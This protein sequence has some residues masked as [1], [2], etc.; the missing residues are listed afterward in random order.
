MSTLTRR[1]F[2]RFAGLAAGSAVFPGIWFRYGKN[3]RKIRIGQI[4]TSHSHAEDKI[5]TLKKLD[6]M[7]ELAG[8]A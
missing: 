6:H 3:G 5:E 8:I 7:F 1:E 4:G 2:T